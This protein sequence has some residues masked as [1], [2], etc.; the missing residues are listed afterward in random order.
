MDNLKFMTVTFAIGLA[1][2]SFISAVLMKIVFGE[3][4][5]SALLVV[6]LLFLVGFFYSY[7]KRKEYLYENESEKCRPS[8]TGNIKFIVNSVYYEYRRKYG[9]IIDREIDVNEN[10]IVIRMRFY[11]GQV[12]TKTV[13][14]E[15][16][17]EKSK[18]TFSIEGVYNGH[19]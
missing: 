12:R 4:Y 15:K 7:N 8:N 16:Y 2:I 6:D 5:L 1:T 14:I 11:D 10:E 3:V 17:V 13:D 19:V 9:D 18:V